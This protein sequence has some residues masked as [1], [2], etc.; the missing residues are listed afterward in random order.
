MSKTMLTFDMGDSYIKIVKSEGSKVTVYTKQ[1]PENM[2]KDGVIEMPLMMSDFLKQLKKE[3]KLPKVDCG[4]VVPDELT[5]CRKLTL[6]AM[7][8]AQLE[9]NLPFEF[10]D[11]ISGKPQRYVYDYAMQEMIYDEEG[12]PKEMVLTGAV[13]SKESV[14]KYVDMFKDA[15]FKLRTLIPQEIAVTNVMKQAV[16]SGKASADKVYCL[17]NL[18]HRSTQ[19]YMFKGDKLDVLR[20]IYLG[21]VTIDATIAE[22]E[23]ID[24]FVAR[25]Y[26][27]NNFNGVLERESCHETFGRIAVEVMKVINFYRFSNRE[28][29]LEDIYFFGGCSNIYELCDSIAETNGLEMKSMT[30]LLPDEVEKSTDMIG[31][32]AMGVAMQ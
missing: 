26:K 22:M 10:S 21:G 7:T 16:A 31:L 9:V 5:V 30:E 23:N 25:T 3:F 18:G 27:H 24:A 14:Y 28:S 8:E 20:N 13:M 1:M 19:V 17:V 6:P 12:Q 11:Y 32:Y 29:E 2:V 15:G 4:M